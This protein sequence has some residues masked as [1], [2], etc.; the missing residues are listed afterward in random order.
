MRIGITKQEQVELELEQLRELLEVFHESYLQ[1]LSDSLHLE[2]QIADYLKDTF[3]QQPEL[4]L[5][6]PQELLRDL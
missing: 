5:K 2:R 1:E 6:T 4:V 3:S